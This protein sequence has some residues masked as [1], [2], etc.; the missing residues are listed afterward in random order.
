MTM[1]LS[2]RVV[3]VCV[4]FGGRLTQAFNHLHG[5]TAHVRLQG[6]GSADACPW[7]AL[8]TQPRATRREKR[9]RGV[10]GC[11]VR[12]GEEGPGREGLLAH[13]RAAMGSSPAVIWVGIHTTSVVF[14]YRRT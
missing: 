4:H 6:M 1:S 7:L 13:V 8:G 14:N 9:S 3:Y 5:G 10:V 2:S 11:T 12:D